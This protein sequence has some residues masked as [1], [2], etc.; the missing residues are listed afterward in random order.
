MQKSLQKNSNYN[1]YDVNRDGEVDD[2]ELTDMQ[3]I[4]EIERDNRK[5]AAQ[6]RMAWVAIWSMIIFTIVLFSPLVSD[7]RVNALADLLGLFYIAQA[8]VVGAFMGVSAWMS[9]K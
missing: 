9:R 8:G 6:R 4:E 7:A 5:Q 1:K 3:K 2:D